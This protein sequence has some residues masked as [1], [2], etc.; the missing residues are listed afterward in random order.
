MG[1][2]SHCH[3]LLRTD[4]WTSRDLPLKVILFT[5][6]V[7]EIME[8]EA[9][10]EISSSVNNL[11]FILT[12]FIYGKNRQGSEWVVKRFERCARAREEKSMGVPGLRLVTRQTGCLLQRALSYKELFPAKRC[13]QGL[14][15]RL[16]TKIK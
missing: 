12:S 14:L 11:F 3:T 1:A 10:E 13:L 4:S 7:L 6:F 9:R 8:G 5:Q 16:S 2:Q 15:H